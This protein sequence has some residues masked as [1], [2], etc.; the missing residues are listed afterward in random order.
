MLVA[1][2]LLVRLCAQ[3]LR[4]VRLRTRVGLPQILVVADRA[5]RA[6]EPSS[7]FVEGSAPPRRG[8]A[9]PR[10]DPKEAS[11]TALASMALTFAPRRVSIPSDMSAS[12]ITGRA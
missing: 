9:L 6:S 11:V 3:L 1:A 4:L 7:L 12:Q 5:A 2:G 8:F 10:A